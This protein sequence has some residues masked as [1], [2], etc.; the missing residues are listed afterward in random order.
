MVLINPKGCTVNNIIN[1]VDNGQII[2]CFVY[3]LLYMYIEGEA[4]GNAVKVSSLLI[5]ISDRIYRRSGPLEYGQT[6]GSL[7]IQA[8]SRPISTNQAVSGS[9][10][11]RGQFGQV[12]A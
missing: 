12:I 9:S 6:N 7:K 3:R 5:Y 10:V 1:I 4:G 11:A 2:C 8:R